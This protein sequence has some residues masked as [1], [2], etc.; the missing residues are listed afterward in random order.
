[1]ESSAQVIEKAPTIRPEPSLKTAFNLAKDRKSSGIG[2]WYEEGESYWYVR[3]PNEHYKTTENGLR[4]E[5]IALN[6]LNKI[7]PELGFIIPK[8]RLF[9]DK[10]EGIGLAMEDL[11][12]VQKISDS[13]HDKEWEKISSSPQVQASVL[14]SG[15]L[16]M[17]TPLSSLGRKG[18]KFVWTDARNSLGQWRRDDKNYY[19]RDLVELKKGTR[20]YSL[21]EQVFSQVKKENLKDAARAIANLDKNYIVD[22][23]LSA[24]LSDQQARQII[25]RIFINIDLIKREFSIEKNPNRE[26]AVV[27]N[28][29]NLERKLDQGPGNQKL[30]KALEKAKKLTETLATVKSVDEILEKNTIQ[31]PGEVKLENYKLAADESIRQIEEFERKLR[32][33]PSEKPDGYLGLSQDEAALSEKLLQLKEAAIGPIG[34]IMLRQKTV[35]KLQREFSVLSNK[36]RQGWSAYKKTMMPHE[37]TS[38]IASYGWAMCESYGR[39]STS[40]FESLKLE[41]LVFG[42]QIRFKASTGAQIRREPELNNTLMRFVAVPSNTQ[43]KKVQELAETFRQVIPKTSED[44]ENAVIDRLDELILEMQKRNKD[45]SQICGE[46]RKAVI[47]HVTTHNWAREMLKEGMMMSPV[48]QLKGG[49]IPR[50]TSKGGEEKLHAQIAYSINSAEPWHFGGE[51]AEKHL[52]NRTERTRG[53]KTL[54]AQWAKSWGGTT[55]RAVAFVGHYSE[56]VNQH[57]FEELWNTQGDFM[58]GAPELHIF[59]KEYDKDKNPIGVALDVRSHTFIIPVE[60][61]GSWKSYL[62]SLKDTRG[63]RLYDDKF[64]R[65]FVKTYPKY[66]DLDTYLEQWGKETF[67]NQPSVPGIIIATGNKGIAVDEETPLFRWETQ[68][69]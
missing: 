5:Y 39:L 8:V 13:Y 36:L 53:A 40:G 35:N 33:L 22:T 57:Q 41:K 21:D 60:E 64:I 12:F 63:K 55:G 45:F 17:E 23:V 38:F 48:E 69:D 62:V 7:G 25:R 24:G 19:Y 18:N 2:T 51:I 16:D 31:K 67:S 9:N 3:F 27:E 58:H 54:S 66:L 68:T 30:I 34:F 28:W 42:E 6:L 15:F 59:D 32:D 50:V 56:V 14:I 43:I 11:G 37:L 44:R 20:Q 29:L 52:V 47:S 10:K 4:N 65:Q 46:R 1:M 49:K 61:E 26:Q